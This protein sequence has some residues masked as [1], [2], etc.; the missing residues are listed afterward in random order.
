MVESGPVLPDMDYSN[1]YGEEIPYSLII[2]N[3]NQET[4]QKKS[5][6]TWK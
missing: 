5:S 3:L 4:H 6:S 1:S 2:K